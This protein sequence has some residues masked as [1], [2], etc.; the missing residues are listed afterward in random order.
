M[1]S[2]AIAIH[3]GA[4]TLSKSL[5]NSEREQAYRKGLEDALL[6]GIHILEL[7]GSAIDAVEAAVVALEDNPLFNA[8]KGSVFTNDGTHEMDACIMNGKDLSCGAVCGVKHIKNPIKL[9]R[10]VMEKS[11]HILLAS[12]GAEAFA[13]LHQIETADDAYFYDAL[14]YEQWQQIKNTGSSALDHNVNVE[15]KFGTVG[16]VALD[17]NGNLAAATSTGGMTN[18]KFG[19]VGDSPIPGAGTYANNRTCAVS[20]TGHGEFFMKALA[21]YDVSALMEYK[22]LTLA[23]AAELVIHQK[24]FPMGG[25]GGLIAIDRNGNISMPFNSEGMY[26]GSFSPDEGMKVS[27]Y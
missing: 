10:C 13:A 23:D 27:I 18:K 15:K 7:N 2:F 14:R 4:G 26:R 9:A 16:A 6:A 5:M 17:M 8:G 11:E 22:M 21:A 20:C 12:S 19:R 24:L 1:K 3:G 25:E